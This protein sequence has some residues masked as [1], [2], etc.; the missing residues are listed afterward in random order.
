[1]KIGALAVVQTSLQGAYPD[2]LLGGEDDQKSNYF[3]RTVIIS[4]VTL[5]KRSNF[6]IGQ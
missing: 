2:H 4:S 3:I 5:I 1:M 6:I